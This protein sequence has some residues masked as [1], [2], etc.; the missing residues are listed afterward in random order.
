M[1]LFSSSQLRKQRAIIS[2]SDLEAMVAH[3]ILRRT[4]KH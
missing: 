1:P 3:D 4:T 2:S